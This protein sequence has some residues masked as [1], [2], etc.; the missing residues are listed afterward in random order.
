MPGRDQVVLHEAA[1]VHPARSDPQ[2]LAV[3]GEVADVAPGGGQMAALEEI[4]AQGGEVL[5]GGARYTEGDCAKGHF[6]QP[7][8][9]RAHKGM[10]IV[11]EE[12]FAPILYLM[13]VDD[14]DDAI[15]A[16][17]DVPQGLSSAIFTTSLRSAERWSRS[18]AFSPC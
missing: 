11:K 14:L 1:L 9:V 10:A 13:E 12:T 15:H 5:C 3:P 17:N 4:N 8:I 2:G 18:L 16:Q 6:V 7:T